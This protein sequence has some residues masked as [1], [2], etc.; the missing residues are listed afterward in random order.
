MA[1]AK[2]P[3]EPIVDAKILSTTTI[4]SGGKSVRSQSIFCGFSGDLAGSGKTKDL[5]RKGKGS[6]INGVYVLL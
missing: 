3:A 1:N 5:R 2:K 4:I 6:L